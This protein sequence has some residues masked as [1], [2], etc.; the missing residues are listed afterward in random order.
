MQRYLQHL[1]A[2]RRYSSHTLDNYRR[3]L[4][5]LCDYIGPL[6]IDWQQVI[7]QDVRDFAAASHRGGLASRSIARRLSAARG[8]FQFLIREGQLQANP[9]QGVPAP[10]GEKKLPEVLDADRLQHLLD[11]PSQRDDANSADVRERAILELFYSTGLRLA[12]LAALDCADLRHQE[13]DLEVVGKGSKARHVMVGGKARESL[14]D[15]LAVRSQWLEGSGAKRED[16]LFI[17]QRGGRLS[18]RGIQQRIADYA[19]RRGLDR[20]LHP[21]MLRHSFATHLLESSGDLRA[22]QKLLGHANIGTTQ[23]YTH[24]DFQ[25]LANTYDKAHPRAKRKKDD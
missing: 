9:A 14:D 15:W 24:L 4:K 13:R 21:H 10:R 1:M 7:G 2:E 17:N 23:I 22:V 12:E 3:D 16:A 20:N 19:Q 5:A 6:P 8:F 25:H 11:A 18:V